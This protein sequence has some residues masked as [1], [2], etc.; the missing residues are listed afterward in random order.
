MAVERCK[1]G[2]I[3]GQCSLCKDPLGPHERNYGEYGRVVV[4]GQKAN[5]TEEKK[6]M[7]ACVIEGCR[8]KAVARGLCKSHWDQWRKGLIVHPITKQEWKPADNPAKK[9]NPKYGPVKN[10]PRE[11][12]MPVKDIKAACTSAKRPPQSDWIAIEIELPPDVYE[13]LKAQAQADYRDPARQIAY[14]VDVIV[15]NWDMA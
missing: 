2:L 12:D 13:K 4:G 11:E 1:H 15:N 9:E 7:A 8:D 5:P 14:C 6:D 3:I 10:K